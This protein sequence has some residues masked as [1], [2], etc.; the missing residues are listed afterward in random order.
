MLILI[1]LILCNIIGENYNFLTFEQSDVFIDTFQFSC[2]D[3]FSATAL[4]TGRFL[5]Y[6]PNDS[7]SMCHRVMLEQHNIIHVLMH[8][9]KNCTL[10][11]RI[12]VSTSVQQAEL[13][14]RNIL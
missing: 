5:L 9:Y 1:L 3:V 14:R 4:V 8:V 7:Y 2:I 13:R 6:V 11:I 12:G 10:L